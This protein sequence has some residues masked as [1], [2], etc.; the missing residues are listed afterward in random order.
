[1]V[2]MQADQWKVAL[3]GAV[4]AELAQPL[5]ETSHA[6]HADPE[7]TFDEHRAC[8]RLAGA[9]EQAGFGVERGAGGLPTAF[10]AELRGAAAGPTI[11]ILAEYDAL[12]DVGH[13]CGHNIIAT[14][15]LG[16]GLA[17]AA[18]SDALN[19]TIL[20]I[21]TPAEEGGGGKILLAEAGVFEGVDAA[22]MMH[23]ATRNMV[24]RGALANSVVELIFHGKAAHAASAPDLGVSALEAVILTFNGFDA[25][26]VHLRADARVHGIITH[27]GD[28][29]NIIPSRASARFSVRAATRA[30][31]YEL[32]D[33]LQHAAEGAAQASGA[34]LE[35]IE[36][37]GY[38]TM[39]PNP[40]IA[41][42]MERNMQALGLT[43]VDPVPGERMGSTDMGDISQLMPAIHAY[44][45]IAP[46]DV[47]G[48]SIA[49]AA[50]AASERGDAAV[51]NGA[52]AL[53]MTAADLLAEPGLLDTARREHHA[54]VDSGQALGWQRWH[55]AAARYT[56]APV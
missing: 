42:A 37:R 33:R 56:G 16:A 5:L 7:R 48:H 49:M 36:H 38:D 23:P 43:V 15:A 35:W 46:E 40:A 47:P 19:G 39:L 55:D 34:R 25:Q 8:E 31:Q 6:I 27:G 30:Y 41:S 9:L 24:R 44:F 22:I 13:G 21:G 4:D 18:T 54:M 3:Q 1:M 32:V 29:V 26:R 17:L 28:A 45:A 14:T 50:A 52:K 12:P 51:L 11:A 20:V 10:R 53:A 2:Q